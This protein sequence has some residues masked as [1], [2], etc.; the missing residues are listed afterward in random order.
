MLVQ[1]TVAP[2]L[3]VIELGLK[4]KFSILIAALR[5]SLDTVGGALDWLLPYMLQPLTA[6]MEAKRMSSQKFFFIELYI[7]NYSAMP[8]KQK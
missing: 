5:L 4:E 6:K 3:T 7:I 8:F 1:V 2:F